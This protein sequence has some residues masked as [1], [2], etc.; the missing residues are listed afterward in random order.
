M[1]VNK[2]LKKIYIILIA[3]I[4]VVIAI[5]AILLIN[6][7]TSKVIISN[8]E[9]KQL[10]NTNALTMMYETEAGSGEYQVSSD[11]TWPQDGYVFNEQLSSCENGSTLTWD[12]E[13]KRVIVSTS[14]SDKC[15]VYFDKMVPTFADICR[16]E[17]SNTLACKVATNYTTDGENGLYYHD[18]TGSYT[19]ADQEA[20]DNSYRYAGANPN[21]Y[22]CFGATGADCQDEDNQYRIIGVFNNQVKL[23]KATSYGDYAWN[24]SMV[25]EWNE[26]T[27]PDIYATLN[28]TYYNTIPVEWQN[29]IAESTWQVG[30]MNFSNTNTAKQY[31]D[32][33]VG[34]GQ[35]G[36][37]E[38][39]KIGLMYVSDYGYGANPEK[40]TTT[41][42][43]DNF[44]TD[45]WIYF[46]SNE[47]TISQHNPL[48]TFSID[49]SYGGRVI[50][51]Q[52][53][54]LFAVRP[55]FYLNS[56]VTYISGSGTQ[57]D[58]FRIA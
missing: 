27:K 42:T 18:G 50:I 40:W 23:I 5:V 56:T 46:S 32:V 26:N 39:M 10:I 15:Y 24:P 1:N 6:N 9:S 52:N 49:S 25:N 41:L 16:E 14:V 57:S 37:E 54:R 58:P 7:S 43:E 17:N 28:T 30:G 35:S 47:W 29:L 31:Y 19:N 20:G 4:L 11:T 8:E 44:G 2:S 53:I 45:N 12:N 13:N 21:N 38:T 51:I 48:F 22:V 3:I 36:Y 34:T 33:E 55:S